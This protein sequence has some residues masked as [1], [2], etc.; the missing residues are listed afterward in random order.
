MDYEHLLQRAKETI[1][2]QIQPNKKFEV[3]ELFPGHEWNAL[4]RGER[5]QFGV[6]FS[7]AVNEGRMD[8]VEKCEN[9]KSGHNQYIKRG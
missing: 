2:R 4:P 8:M 3:K 9:G 6:Y 7:A 5:S 1:E